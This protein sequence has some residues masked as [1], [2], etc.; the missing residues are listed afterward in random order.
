MRVH[1]LRTAVVI[2]LS[3]AVLGLTWQ[4]QAAPA[5]QAALVPHI[6]VLPG[7][8]LQVGQ[9]VLFDASGTE[10]ENE[11]LKYKGRYEWDFGDD[12]GARFG[13]PYYFSGE[14]GMAISH[15]YMRPGVYTVTLTVSIWDQFDGG[16][17]P[18]GDPIEVASATTSVTVVG[19]APLLPPWPEDAM[20]LAMNLDGNLSDSSPNAQ[21]G[22]WQG[23]VGAFVPGIAGQAADLTGGAYISVTDAGV[24]SGLD[25]ISVSFWARKSLTSTYGYLLSKPGQF[26]VRI[27][28]IRIF[29]VSLITTQGTA[30]AT[31]YLAYDVD[32]TH[33]HHYAFTYD[34]NALRAF[35]DGKELATRPYSG[36]VANGTDSLLIGKSATGDVFG[37]YVD[38]VRIYDRALSR[39]DLF[40]GLDLT[41]ASFHARTA[42]YIYA[43]IPSAVYLDPANKLK[44]TVSGDNGY[45]ANIFEKTGLSVE[46][47]F[48]LHNAALPAG[49]YTLT[50]QLL[51]THDAVL[52]Q[53]NEHF[54][55]PYAGA[56]RVGIDENNAFV[57]DGQPFFP[58]TS[59]LLN[60]ENI[61]SWKEN[62]YINT[63]NAEGYYP[64]HNLASWADYLAQAEA[65][66]VYAFGPERWFDLSLPIPLEPAYRRHFARNANI[67]VLADYVT[68]TRDMPALL[69]WQWMDEPDLGGYSQR[70]PPAVVRAWTY[71]SNLNDPQHP[72]GTNFEGYAYLPYY[73]NPGKDYDFMNN[74]HLFG[75]KSRFVA[76]MLGID[77][78]PL[79]YQ[80]KA[81]LNDPDRGPIDLYAEA[82]DRFIANNK[83]M[84]PGFSWVEVCDVRAS[85]NTPPP[86]EEQ[87][88]MEA[89]LNV[90]HGMKAIGWFHYFEYDTI[91]YGAMTKFTDQINRLAPAVLG[92]E[93]EIH[94]SDDANAQANR[95]D[96]LVR[97]HDDAIYVFA[98][99]VTE[100]EPFAGA[101]YT[102]TEPASL[103]VNFV[104]DA[105]VGG[106]AQVIDEHRSVPV[107][108]GAFA[109]A[110]AR[111]AVHI[112]RIPLDDLALH[113]QGG[114]HRID[115]TW[116]VNSTLPA[117]STWTISYESPGSAFL[118]ITGLT[119]T[120]RAHTLNGLTNYVRYTVTLSA[121]VDDQ[122]LMSATATA[123][124]TDRNIY[125][126]LILR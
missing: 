47:K 119:H 69:S 80:L 24:F 60:P 70:V 84:V 2:L 108:G 30:R 89:W 33:W 49:A 42:Q 122:V 53:M 72:A 99:R 91:R 3:F 14:G 17:F 21:Q 114:N 25:E 92:P 96:T 105:P 87:V 68:A 77:V 109:D 104:L 31:S 45:T 13:D 66:E 101:L 65:N 98:V 43:N 63:L 44:V 93:P 94:V 85:N 97:L 90:V 61:A 10:Y 6:T 57:V 120:L 34:G 75:G 118:P 8:T 67:N 27:G 116:D 12:Y 71:A 48:L 117:T 121:M 88:L 38:E 22:Q 52:G 102:V 78:Y 126:P 64:Q 124:P 111:N 58:V 50:A 1:K 55:K 115:L 32:N 82:I 107:N 46:E 35:I 11:E 123:M 113:A 79:E 36:T 81:N 51:D 56:P 125:L 76:D 5:R 110:F 106:V 86:T 41:H 62:G 100:P 18:I 15:F 39:N 112:Y 74:A 23:G 29:D 95:V 83:A 16:D 20:L 40:T 19:Q 4:T 103:N 28:S 26:S 7:S 54:S 37:G 73:D 9:E 59:W